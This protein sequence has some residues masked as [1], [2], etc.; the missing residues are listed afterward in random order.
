GFGIDPADGG[1]E[2]DASEYL[3]A[4]DVLAREPR[5]IGS[6]G[7]MV[8]EY[9]GLETPLLVD[10]SDLFVVQRA[11]EDVGRRMDVRVH[12]SSNGTDRRW[13]RRKNAHLCE[14]LARIH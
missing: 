8:L 4:R 5:A 12:K 1:I 11:A 13:R 9:E 6:G 7:D 3:E 14:G 10:A 2:H